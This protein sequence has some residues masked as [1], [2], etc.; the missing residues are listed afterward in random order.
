MKCLAEVVDIFPHA[1]YAA[2]THGL[3]S[4]WSYLVHTIPDVT[5]LLQTLEDVI[6]LSFISALFGRP[7]CSSI[8]RDLYAL[9]VCL[10][11]LGL[12][13][14]CSA[15]SSAFHDSEKLIITAPL[16][17]LIAA[18]CMTQTID[19]DHVH[20]LKQSIR[21]TIVITRYYLQIHCIVSSPPLLNAVLTLPGNLGHPLGLLS[22]QYKNMAFICT[23][24]IFRMLCSCAIWHNPTQYI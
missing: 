19:R 13:N 14:P 5:D 20:H 16:V 1:A 15:A 2:F 21:K 18:Q 17:A 7:P 23:R 12:M 4:R 10:G 3:F 22:C 8:E 24:V 6:H 9:P 11:G